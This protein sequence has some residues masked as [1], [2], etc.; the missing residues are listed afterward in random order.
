MGVEDRRTRREE[1]RV[2]AGGKTHFSAQQRETREIN[3][4]LFIQRS[5]LWCKWL[6]Q[7]YKHDRN[8]IS[9]TMH[10]EQL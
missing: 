9:E 7:S 8:Y 10:I 2:Q 1:E 3:C 5:A 6:N 4:G